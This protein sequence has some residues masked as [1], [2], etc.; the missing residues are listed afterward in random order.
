MDFIN[1]I[2]YMSNCGEKDFIEWFKFSLVIDLCVWE[3]DGGC[4]D[5]KFWFGC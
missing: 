4:G 2:F 1:S 5:K 3:K